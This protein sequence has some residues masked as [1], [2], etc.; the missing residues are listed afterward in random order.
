[1]KEKKPMSQF[2]MMLKYNLVNLFFR[3]FLSESFYN[4]QETFAQD[5]LHQTKANTAL[6]RSAGKQVF[7]GS[8]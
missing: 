3:I 5:Y 6:E 2:Y 7:A 1:M 8:C 4:P